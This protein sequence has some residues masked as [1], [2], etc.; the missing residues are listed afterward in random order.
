M[1][2]L[3]CFQ[4]RLFLSSRT[5]MN[6]V[7]GQLKA[8]AL[9]SA[10]ANNSP[11]KNEAQGWKS[12]QIIDYLN[13]NFY[14]ENRKFFD[15][16]SQLK[17]LYS[18]CKLCFIFLSSLFTLFSDFWNSSAEVAERKMPYYFVLFHHGRNLFSSF[19]TSSFTFAQVDFND[20]VFSQ[21][22]RD[23]LRRCRFL[24]ETS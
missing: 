17:T 1:L 12:I 15:L 14:R 13:L 21:F 20:T 23:H 4:I 3:A 16:N 18:Y 5:E 24:W 2:K 8:G 10:N 19:R 11:S 7:I 6:T 9:S 22:K